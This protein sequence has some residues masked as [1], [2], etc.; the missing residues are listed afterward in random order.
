MVVGEL[1]SHTRRT[2]AQAE[3]NAP[4]TRNLVIQEIKKKDSQQE[5][6][7]HHSQIKKHR[8]TSGKN[9]DSLILPRR[10]S[11]LDMTDSVTNETTT[12]DSNTVEAIPRCDPR[13]LL[14]SSIEHGRHQHEC[15]IRDGFE[16]TTQHSQHRQGRE[17]VR[18]RLTHEQSSPQE[19]VEGEIIRGRTTLHDQVGRDSPDKP[20]EVE[21]GA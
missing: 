8:D 10:K 6:R 9:P 16:G 11:T 20:T 2:N 13:W 21:D 4:T 12:G 14:F 18:R 15:R 3:Q 1:G 5:K 7:S 19:D 17:C